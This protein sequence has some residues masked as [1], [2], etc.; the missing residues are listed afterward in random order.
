ME[1]LLDACGDR[2]IKSHPPP[3]QRPLDHNI[4]FPPQLRQGTHEIPDWK[5]LMKHIRAEGRVN[6]QDIMQLL[7]N[8]I[9]I[10]KKEPNVLLVSEP[11]VVV[12]DIHG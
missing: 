5:C 7:M 4:L 1:P 2:P 6:K 9:E 8:V 11:V 10:M 12:G 3:P